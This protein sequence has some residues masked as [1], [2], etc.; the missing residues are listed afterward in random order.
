[1]FADHII[2]NGFILFFKNIQTR[3]INVNIQAKFVPYL[4]LNFTTD[5]EQH[6][7]TQEGRGSVAMTQNLL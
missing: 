7:S 4:L 6:V 5:K 2:L 1:M 3:K